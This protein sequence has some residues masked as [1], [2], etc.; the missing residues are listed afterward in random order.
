M[1][2]TTDLKLSMLLSSTT[3]WLSLFQLALLQVTLQLNL[4][5]YEGLA[6]LPRGNTR[7]MRKRV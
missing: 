4:K 3:A 7:N 6:L 1:G 2:L 5:D